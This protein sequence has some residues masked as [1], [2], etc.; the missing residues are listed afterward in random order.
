MV[1]SVG[2]S[3]REIVINYKALNKISLLK[4]II[5]SGTLE[6]DY[7]K[8]QKVILFYGG[9]GEGQGMEG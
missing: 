2:S 9:G 4:T 3:A 1:N 6:Y 7:H 8:L 5:G